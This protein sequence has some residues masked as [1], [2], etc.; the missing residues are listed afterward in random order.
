MPEY[1]LLLH[2]N[3]A[4]WA[5]LSPEDMQR[6]IQRYSTWSA[7]LA[8]RGQLRGGEKL[9]D[10]GGKHL[11]RNGSNAKPS[12]VDGPYSEV[13]EIVGGFFKVAAADYDEAVQLASD[14]PH[15]DFGWIEIREIE[16]T[17]KE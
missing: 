16:P 12:V 15:L 3:P 5:A 1:M 7:G 6:V 13:K 10:E 9:R 17:P 2:E 14:C 8:S 4:G 11:R